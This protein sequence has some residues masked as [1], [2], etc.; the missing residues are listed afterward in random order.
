MIDDKKL[1]LLNLKKVIVDDEDCREIAMITQAYNPAKFAFIVRTVLELEEISKEDFIN[2]CN[3]ANETSQ[4]EEISDYIHEYVEAQYIED[5]SEFIDKI[6]SLIPQQLLLYGI[7]EINIEDLSDEFLTDFSDCENH[8]E[9]EYDG[10]VIRAKIAD[11]LDGIEDMIEDYDDATEEEIE[12]LTELTYAY[13]NNKEC[14]PLFSVLTAILNNNKLLK[15]ISIIHAT[16]LGITDLLD[17]NDSVKVSLQDM[18]YFLETIP[19][20]Y[21]AYSRD[22]MFEHSNDDIDNLIEAVKITLER[23]IDYYLPKIDFSNKVLH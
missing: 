12:D 9:I 3:V 11:D 16:K 23:G 19:E 20:F 4:I 10:G 17:E 18:V 21:L 6:N 7:K 2:L 15:Y 1:A 13:M 5:E 22:S 8:L 14:T